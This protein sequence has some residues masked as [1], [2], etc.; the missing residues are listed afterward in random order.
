MA[1]LDPQNN[2][3]QFELGEGMI[4]ADLGAGSGFYTIASARAVGSEG[5]VYAVDVQKDFLDRIKTS[6]NVE[7]LFNIEVIWGDIE[8]IGGTKLAEMSVDAVIIS[9][10]LFQVEDKDNFL[11]EVNRILRPKGKVLVIDWSD[12]FS[13]MGPHPESVIT[14][15][16]A[17]ELFKNKGFQV[18]K[19]ISAGDN[20]YGIIF[21]KK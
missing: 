14:E 11:T 18:E 12:S 1:F 6:A 5:R 7:N 3:Q 16:Q 17:E 9:N 21:R 4:V 10:T 19:Q 2:I 15:A 8:K 13:G 20:H